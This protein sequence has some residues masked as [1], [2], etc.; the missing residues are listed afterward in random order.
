MVSLSPSSRETFG[1][2]WSSDFARLMSGLRCFG[3]SGGRGRNT[4]F[5]ELPVRERI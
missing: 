3:S 1:A 2:Q 5:E 4:S